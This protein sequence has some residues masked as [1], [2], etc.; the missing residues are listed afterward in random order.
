MTNKVVVVFALATTLLM[1][2]PSQAFLVAVGHTNKATSSLTSTIDAGSIFNDG[3]GTETTSVR[4]YDILASQPGNDIRITYATSGDGF[5]TEFD[6][7]D[8]VR[9]NTA[10]GQLDFTFELLNSGFSASLEG[11]W[12]W[13]DFGGSRM[14]TPGGTVTNTT[15]SAS[16][17]IPGDNSDTTSFSHQTDGMTS[18]PIAN[19]DAFS[20]TSADTSYR[21]G[22]YTLDIIPDG[23]IFTIDRSTGNISLDTNTGTSDI[24]GYSLTTE[25]GAF[26][27][28]NWMSVADNYDGDSGGFVDSDDEWVKLTGAGST[29]DLSEFEL[30]APSGDGGTISGPINL[31]NAWVTGS[32]EDVVAMV[33]LVGSATQQEAAVVFVDGAGVTGDYDGDSDVDGND[34]LDWQR[35]DTTPAGLT[36]WENNYGTGVTPVSGVSG[37]A[38]V[39]EPT[40]GLLL[41]M[42]LSMSGALTVVRRGRSLRDQ[43]MI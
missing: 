21:I 2:V 32:P 19:G 7:G 4:E 1:Q 26:N 42:G 24:L 29:S 17:D 28:A 3:I 16:F 23:L 25:G 15:S 5:S 10:T 22:F 18:I 39:P 9:S 8:G 13:Q 43:D 35:N 30:G 27:Q 6:G 36:D 37:L 40:S 41:L 14:I 11:V 31:G 20:I 38:A 34:F 33:S 12:I